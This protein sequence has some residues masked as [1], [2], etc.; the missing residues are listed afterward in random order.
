[1]NHWAVGALPKP[2]AG[3]GKNDPAARSRRP[4]VEADAVEFGQTRG[5]DDGLR[6]ART[7]G[8]LSLRKES[9]SPVEESA[10]DFLV[11]PNLPWRRVRRYRGLPLPNVAAQVPKQFAG[12]GGANAVTGLHDRDSFKLY[13][14]RRHLRED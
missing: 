12:V 13:K 9:F 5:R 2:E 10:Q 6:R 8:Q 7:L 11:S 1:R 4:G 3:Q 14:Q